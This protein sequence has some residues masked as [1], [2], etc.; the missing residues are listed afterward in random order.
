MYCYI[1]LTLAVQCSTCKYWRNV[2]RIVLL[3]PYFEE[4]MPN[5]F[6]LYAGER[7][8]DIATSIGRQLRGIILFKQLFDSRTERAKLTFIIYRTIQRGIDSSLGTSTDH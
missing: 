3:L 6:H 5:L 4:Q 7:I 2:P 1:T 8:I